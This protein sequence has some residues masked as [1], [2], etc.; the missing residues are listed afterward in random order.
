[1][2]TLF[3]PLA[4]L[5]PLALAVM[6]FG[7]AAGALARGYAGFGLSALLVASW[8]L[9]GAPA[10]A[11]AVALLLEVVASLLQA[12]SVWRHVPWRRVGLL[13][14]GAAVGTP[15]GVHL[16]AATSEQALRLGI[17]LFIL[18]TSLVL[19]AGLRLR[20]RGARATV[21][22][23]G[24]ASGVC[25]G[26]VAMG[27]LPVAVFLTAEGADPRA[28]RAAVVAYFFLLD[29]IGLSFLARAGFVRGETVSLA[30]LG[31]PVLAAGMWL[32]G[33]HFLGAS[34][35]GFRR[36]T[37]TLLVLLAGVGI[38]RALGG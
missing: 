6:I 13:L 14:A 22:A 16:L 2:P 33:R 1:M 28:L 5:G 9:V 3:E 37:L 27:G 4:G 24:L 12:A 19:L 31:L 15:L 8:S 36:I 35:E 21:M 11:V 23:V 20:A 38:A 26:A 7:L 18:A 30:V 17:A 25:N 34:P 10:R 32:G 29:I